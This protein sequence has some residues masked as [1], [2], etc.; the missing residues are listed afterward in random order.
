MAGSSRIAFSCPAF[1]IGNL[2]GIVPKVAEHFEIFEILADAN[3]LPE[4]IGNTIEDTLSPFGLRIQLHA[5]MSDINIASLNPRMRELSIGIVIETMELARRIEASAVTFHPGSLSPM[6]KFSLERVIDLN[7]DAVSRISSA[8]DDLGVKIA[9]EN[10]PNLWVTICKEPREL[11]EAIGG[12]SSGF[13]FDIGHSNSTSGPRSFLES[14]FLMSRLAN[15]HLHDNNGDGDPHMAIGEGGIDFD[16]A[17]K[18]ILGCG[19]RG[20]FVI[21]ARDLESGVRGKAK[22]GALLEKATC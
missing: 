10:M 2:D 1:T 18:K 4:R 13:C 21:E 22:L 5:P 19:Y 15:M 11:E 20:N 8:A 17:I 3:F 16:S 12:S 6:G 14:D 9:L 7:R